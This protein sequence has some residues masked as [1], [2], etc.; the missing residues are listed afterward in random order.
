MLPTDGGDILASAAPKCSCNCHH[1]PTR[2]NGLKPER[3]L[4][5][6]NEYVTSRLNEM[7]SVAPKENHGDVGTQTLSTGDIVVTKIYFNEATD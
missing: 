6:T 2:I 4:S 5:P 7:D 1:H 3:V